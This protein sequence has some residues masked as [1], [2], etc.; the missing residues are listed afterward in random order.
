MRRISS[1]LQCRLNHK[2]NGSL[3]R[4]PELQ[5]PRSAGSG[6]FLLLNF[7]IKILIDFMALIWLKSLFQKFIY[8]CIYVYK[9]IYIHIHIYIYIYIHTHTE[10]SFIP[11]IYHFLMYTLRFAMS[12]WV[13]GR[14]G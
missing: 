7:A 13:I 8:I 6:N 11:T 1:S 9:S 2:P 12:N 5:G 10:L 3:A 4:A 14:L